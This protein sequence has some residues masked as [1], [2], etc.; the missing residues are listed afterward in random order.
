MITIAEI[1]AV[2]VIAVAIVSLH[3]LSFVERIEKPT[4]VVMFRSHEIIKTTLF[5][6]ISVVIHMDG[7]TKKFL[8]DFVCNIDDHIGQLEHNF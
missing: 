4:T 8:F 7:V 6:I 5:S 1:P 3:F 2:T